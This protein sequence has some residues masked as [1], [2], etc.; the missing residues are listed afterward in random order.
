MSCHII[1]IYLAHCFFW[2]SHRFL[3]HSDF[4]L[5]LQGFG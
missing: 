4:G 2:V 3:R 5:Q 1:S